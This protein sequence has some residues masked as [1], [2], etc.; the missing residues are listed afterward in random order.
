MSRR[1]ILAGIAAGAGLAAVLTA[2]YAAA[3]PSGLVDAACVA[4]AGVLIAARVR[5]G[6]QQPPPVR[7]WY[8]RPDPKRR[9]A[10]SEAD[11]PA[12]QKILSQVPGAQAPGPHH[13]RALRSMLA[14][15][16]AALD[17]P[18][19]V[20]AD[21]GGPSGAAGGPGLDLAALE[22]IVTRLEER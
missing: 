19:A 18:Q 11:F 16:A 4:A 6:G 3:G 17:R 1:M 7:P 20:A 9:P 8:S 13:E 21:L 12:Y 2:A 22:R 10:V 5:L 15:L 14:R